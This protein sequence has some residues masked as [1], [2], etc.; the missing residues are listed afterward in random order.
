MSSD[1]QAASHL[2]LN[3]RYNRRV[4]ANNREGERSERVEIL[5]NEDRFVNTGQQKTGP[6]SE[7]NLPGAKRSGFRVTAVILGVFY[8]LILVGVFTRYILVTLEKEQ[9]QTRY[10]DLNNSYSQLQ[11]QLSVVNNSQLQDEV[12]RLK[13]KIEEKRCSVGW[14]R[15][16]C[17]C[18]FKSTEEK[19]WSESRT[20]CQRTGADLVIINSKE[21][22]DFLTQMNKYGTSWIGLESKKTSSW[23]DKWEWIWVDGSKPQYQGWTVG[24]S[25]MP[26]N[27]STAYINLQGTWMHTNNGSKQW[28]CEKQNR[29]VLGRWHPL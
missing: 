19:T 5:E 21:E 2:N 3:V 18:Y 22:Q 14:E 16:G 10:N 9:L 26:V 1:T 17:S 7:R 29:L 6:G 13:E 23:P 24:V 27:R 15:F 12:K 20:D 8:F 4:Q 25:V 28:I 11:E